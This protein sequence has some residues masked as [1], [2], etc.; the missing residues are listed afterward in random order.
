M[1][2]RKGCSQAYP[3]EP[4]LI[5]GDPSMPTFSAILQ[6]LASKPHA[7]IAASRSRRPMAHVTRSPIDPRR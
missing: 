3:Y 7:G 1:M 5:G 2:F 4:Q 6:T